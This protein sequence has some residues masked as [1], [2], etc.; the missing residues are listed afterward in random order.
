MKIVRGKIRIFGDI[1]VMLDKMKEIENK[2]EGDRE[3]E[4]EREKERDKEVD[5]GK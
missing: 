3:R 2:I 1:F 4:R 5:D